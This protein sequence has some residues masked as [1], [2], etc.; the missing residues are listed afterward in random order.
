MARTVHTPLALPRRV[1]TQGMPIYSAL[2]MGPR[3]IRNALVTL[4]EQ[5][6]VEVVSQ[7]SGTGNDILRPVV[8]DA[9]E[10][11]IKVGRADGQ[12]Y[13][14]RVGVVADDVFDDEDIDIVFG[15]GAATITLAPGSGDVFADID[16]VHS[17]EI[18]TLRLE[19]V[20]IDA[21][22]HDRLYMLY[23]YPL[24][25]RALLP[26]GPYS[27]GVIPPEADVYDQEEPLSIGQYWE[28]VGLAAA[29]YERC[30]GQ[31]ISYSTP[32]E[33]IP[34]PFVVRVFPPSQSARLVCAYRG[35]AAG[36][37][38][39]SAGE[40]EVQMAGAGWHYREMPVSV[41]ELRVT[42]RF[43][44]ICAWW[45]TETLPATL[46][47]PKELWTD[48]TGQNIVDHDD[49]PVEVRP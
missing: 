23:A 6:R 29:L 2:D 19:V 24:R 42:G 20:A 22:G 33:S 26:A 37:A 13:R 9:V 39:F 25:D 10:Y 4:Y 7:T 8:G 38:T 1:S 47:P 46:D 27:D 35:T 34:L 15:G 43:L 17:A 49:A 5:S 14:W 36:W 40:N 18:L 12:T 28:L 31:V 45:V 11:R 48:D 30:Y 3:A 44:S 21:D 16:V 32:I 41:S